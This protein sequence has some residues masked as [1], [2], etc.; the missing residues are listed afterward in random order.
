MSKPPHG[1][2]PVF[3][4]KYIDQVREEDLMIAFREQLPIIGNFI[5]SISEEQSF[6]AYAE[7]KWTLKELLQHVID[8]ERIFNYR[9]LCIARH[10]KVSMPGFDEDQYAAHSN[11][12][13]RTWYSMGKEFQVVRQGTEALF[14]SFSQEAMSS[15]GTS[16]GKPISVAAIGFITVGHFYH[17]RQIVKER[18]L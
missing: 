7:G 13:R 8:T 3:F 10:E 14:D 16:N 5:S 12:N 1:D 4:Q 18:Y 17:H 9:A 6:F 11:A 15:I 2:Y